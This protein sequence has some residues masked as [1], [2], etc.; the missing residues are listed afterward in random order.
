[1]PILEVDNLVKQYR[2]LTAVN[3]VSFSVEPGEIF[4]MIG[5]NGAGKTTTIECCLGLRTAT[6]GNVELVGMNPWADRRGLF[7]KV[8]VQLQETSYQDHIRVGEICELFAAM[9]D[10][11]R[12]WQELLEQFGLADR[13]KA[14]VTKLSGGQRQRL[15]VALAMIPNPQ[16]VFLDELTTGL[17]PRARREM[18]EDIKRLRDNGVTV[19]M[20]THYMEE[21][22]YLCDRVAIIVNGNI[23][24]I[25]SVPALLDDSGLDH[26]ISFSAPGMD[27]SI[28]ESLSGVRGVSRSNGRTVLACDSQHV[29]TDL[30][31]AFD[32]H[33][34]EYADV[35]TRS[36]GLE[37]LFL[38]LTGEE[39]E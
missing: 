2:N 17:D 4:G 27:R 35:R 8:G 31:R 1:M 21:A 23:A 36:P 19:F 6:S 25:D 34:I 7:R 26:E 22:E 39:F 16:I 32:T 12:D 37:D 13:E 14:R 33:R 10:E 9:Y 18:W 30:V 15:T 38:K 29:L 3:G 11:P 20:T 24:A 28:L 5:P